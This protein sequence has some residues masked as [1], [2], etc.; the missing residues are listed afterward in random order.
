MERSV[1]HQ[2]TDYGEVHG[3]C[4]MVVTHLSPD[5]NNMQMAV[6]PILLPYSASSFFMCHFTLSNHEIEEEQAEAIQGSPPTGKKATTQ[7]V[8]DLIIPCT[9]RV[10]Q[11]KIG[12]RLTHSN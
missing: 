2:K 4:R 5:G 1:I 7:C 12:S 3:N 6:S 9:A 10:T 8:E 11:V